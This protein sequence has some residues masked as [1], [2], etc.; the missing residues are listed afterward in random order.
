L[1]GP[2]LENPLVPVRA[3][4][5]TPPVRGSISCSAPHIIPPTFTKLLLTTDAKASQN[6]RM[7][8]LGMGGHLRLFSLVLKVARHGG[9]EFSEIEK[10]PGYRCRLD[11][12]IKP[13][14][15]L[16]R[17]ELRTA[18]TYHRSA[19]TRPSKFRKVGRKNGLNRFVVLPKFIKR[20]ARHD[21]EFIV[22][23][24]DSHRVPSTSS[25]GLKGFLSHPVPYDYRGFLTINSISCLALL[26]IN[27]GSTTKRSDHSCVRPCE[28]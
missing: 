26:F 25:P 12:L 11:V 1:N 23:I 5:L 8:W 28:I 16:G 22:K 4:E 2:E 24:L 10:V 19:S 13:S 17:A 3:I 15:D 21:I 14:R 6:S 20:S 7:V 27:F 18:Y 9:V